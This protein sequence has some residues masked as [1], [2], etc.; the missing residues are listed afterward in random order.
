MDGSTESKSLIEAIDHINIVVEDMEK[1][2]AF[3]S[4]VIEMEAYN[5]ASISGDWVDNLV[6]LEGVQAD[7]TFLRCEVGTNLE[8]IKYI[9]P[10]GKRPENLSISNS[11]G[12]RHIA[13]RVRS[14]D[15]V[16]ERCQKAGVE[17]R[18]E[19]QDVPPRQADFGKSKKRIVYFNDPEGNL[20]EFC[21]YDETL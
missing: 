4:Q 15:S 7:V 12:I 8:L 11:H 3:Y 5:T 17:F 21:S 19:V 18:A 14:I 2:V 1:M 10:P 9:S 20:L 16:V 13:F 6:G